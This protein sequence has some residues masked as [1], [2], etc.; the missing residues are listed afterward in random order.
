MQIEFKTSGGFAFFPAL[1]EPVRLESATL[2]R[3]TAAELERLI[4]AAHFFERP[5]VINSPPV[6]AADMMEY[7]ITI[8][9]QEREHSITFTDPIPDVELR[10]L[11][12]FLQNQNQS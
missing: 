9:D 12:L 3:D 1:A 2:P 8:R 10:K 11:W 4:T 6:G 7:S 5:S